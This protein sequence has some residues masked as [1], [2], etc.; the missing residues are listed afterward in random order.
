M[1]SPDV[2]ARLSDKLAALP[3]SPGVYLFKDATA[4]VIYV[5]KA[6]VLKNR[7][8][9][10][11]TK[12]DD[13]RYQYAR[14]VRA[15][16]DLEVIVTDSEL[17][18]LILESNLVKKHLPRYNVNLKDD[19]RFPYLKV[20]RELYPRIFLTRKTP[21]DGSK[22]YGPYTDV[23]TL[24][25]L[26]RSFKAV[27]KIRNC[28]RAITPEE[29]AKHP[30]KYRPC[31]NYHIGRCAGA[32][33]G[34]I[35]TEDYAVNLRHFLDLVQGR[36]AEL[37]EYM[38]AQMEKASGELRFEDAALW[39]DRIRR[40]EA[41]GERQ[42]VEVSDPVDRD[43]VALAT[44]DEDGCAALFQVRSG[45]LVGRSH[46]Y[47][48][49]VFEKTPTEVL[50]SFLKEYYA[51][52]EALPDEIFLPFE[53][54][55]GEV[56]SE[57]LSRRKG[58]R[59]RLEVPKIGDKAKLVRMTQQ[60]AILLLGELK[61]QKTK[62]E[63]VHHA[64]KSLQRD[65]SLPQPPKRIECFDVSNLH[66]RDAVASLV[67]FQDAK[68][69]KSQ[70]RRFKIRTVEGSDDFAMM[71]EA[72]LRHYRRV[73]KENGPLPDL[74]LVDGGKGQLNRAVQVLKDLGL[75]KIPVAG[76]AKKLEEV[77]LPGFSQ[78]QDIPRNSSALKLLCQVRDEAHR[79]AVTYH[80]QLHK[81]ST[82]FTELD[83]IPGIGQ[84]RKQTLLKHFGSLK[85]LKEAQVDDL[86]LAP[87]I[88]RRLAKQVYLHFHPEAWSLEDDG[89]A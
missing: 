18:A 86:A 20:T 85:S 43:V 73:Q 68:P 49:H 38:R 24:R 42:K 44:E 80:R 21:A 28:D 14:L 39:R 69:A 11:F 59:V 82:L 65:L 9:S 13:G 37:L 6:K 46:F 52:T 78:P 16:A 47:L 79:F 77:F 60:N 1:Y 58:K 8:R 45:R 74:I 4:K 7:V 10:Y 56:L 61:L 88:P 75:E 83:A 54:E 84:A 17:E 40:V 35:T 31:L 63:F 70:Y 51:V 50:E 15:I 67:C 81:K 30:K 22:Y 12:G 53:I 64:L 89:E 41:F 76:L 87:G 25:E 29:A 2:A 27:V 72:I 71:G 57:W 32:C 34:L 48:N 19:K 55:D 23:R 66:G 3:K 62:K 33:A 36:D 5:G 26:L